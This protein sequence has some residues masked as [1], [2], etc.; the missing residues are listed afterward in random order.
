MSVYC[1]HSLLLLIADLMIQFSG[2]MLLR[3]IKLLRCL[4][5]DFIICSI[6]FT[7]FYLLQ[8][9]NIA[10]LC[11]R[12]KIENTFQCNNNCGMSSSTSVSMFVRAL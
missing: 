9:R 2:R 6:A 8:F 10:F 11:G 4:C 5:V 7:F 1:T 12:F 3:S